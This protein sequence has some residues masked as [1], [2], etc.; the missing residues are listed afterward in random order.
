MEVL[1]EVFELPLEVDPEAVDITLPDGFT[2]RDDGLVAINAAGGTY[3]ITATLK[4]V[5]STQTLEVYYTP[6][7]FV[8]ESDVELIITMSADTEELISSMLAGIEGISEDDLFLPFDVTRADGSRE[9]V[10]FTINLGDVL[11]DYDIMVLHFV[12]GKVDY[13]D[14]SVSGSTITVNPE[15]FSPFCIVLSLPEPEPGPDYPIINPGWDDDDYVPLPP[16]IVYEEEEDDNTTEIVACAAAAV[17][18]A[19]MAA[20]LIIERRRN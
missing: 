3:T 9:G 2:F 7:I 12:N 10:P 11:A 20:F 1:S 6:G 8:N 13:P 5:D 17:V 16:Q 14:Y 4:S 19:L 18:A 15:S